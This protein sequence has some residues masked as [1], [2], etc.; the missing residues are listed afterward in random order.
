[1]KNTKIHK[2]QAQ[3]QP[4]REQFPILKQSFD[5]YPLCYL[6]TAATSQKPL[7]VIQAMQDYYLEFNANV[8]RAA[9]HLSS[10]A[11]REYEAVRTNIAQFI[12]A[13]QSA[14]IVFT[15]GATQSINMLAFG[16]TEQF[17]T[18]DVIVIDSAAHHANIVPWQQLAKKT[19][20][21]IIPIPLDKQLRLDVQAYEQ[22]LQTHKVKLVALN[23][24]SNVLG[25]INPI[26]ELIA[27]AKQHHALTLIDGSQA[28][29]HLSI[30][31]QQ[32]NCDFYVFSGHK[33]YGPTGIGILYGR[34][35]ELNKLAPML[36]GGEMIKSVSF[37]GTTFGELPNK[38]EAGTPPIAEVIGLGAA[39]NFIS[40]L[41]AYYFKQ[42]Q[43]LLNYLQNALTHIPQITLYGAHQDNIATLAFNIK[44]EHHQ[45]IG[46][47]LDQQ[48]IA[49]RCGHHCAQPLMQAL[50]IKGCCRA[51]IGIYNNQSDID[52]FITALKAAIELLN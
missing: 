15:S 3:K 50:D 25:I 23:H 28:I 4:L 48:G 36:T 13:K 17:N 12:N 6:D 33:M 18:D 30:D 10:K 47:L 41:D 27:V 51:S 20:A 44:G 45:D 7:Q 32:L 5:G 2:Q 8:H 35:Q 42:E 26:K 9:H 34:Y 37:T 29:A 11:T 24:V 21:K 22:L 14:E 31:V 46:I 40:Q 1:M 52:Q 49:I 39:I 43:E 16:L 19:G 38:L